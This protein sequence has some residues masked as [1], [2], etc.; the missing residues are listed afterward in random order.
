MT[1][2]DPTMSGDPEYGATSWQ[3]FQRFGLNSAGGRAE[4][5]LC[6]RGGIP[7]CRFERSGV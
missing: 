4:T 3:H 7:L 5:A 1:G 2:R 6:Y